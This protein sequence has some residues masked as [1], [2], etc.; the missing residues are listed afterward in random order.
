MTMEWKKHL[1]PNLVIPLSIDRSIYLRKIHEEYF[2][3][4]VHQSLNEISMIGT[5]RKTKRW[6]GLMK[7]KE[8]IRT[9]FTKLE[10][11]HQHRTIIH[12]RMKEICVSRSKHSWIFSTIQCIWLTDFF[13]WYSSSSF[14]SKFRHWFFSHFRR[15]KIHAIGKNSYSLISRDPRAF[16]HWIGCHTHRPNRLIFFMSLDCLDLDNDCRIQRSDF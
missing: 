13:V 6:I 11:L 4:R 12:D 16:T 9:K 10:H 7:R 5:R 14:N 2:E 8:W 1:D 3:D 15:S